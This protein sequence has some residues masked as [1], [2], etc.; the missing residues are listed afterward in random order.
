[1]GSFVTKLNMRHNG[2]NETNAVNNKMKLHAVTSCF[3]FV[4]VD[5]PLAILTYG[6]FYLGGFHASSS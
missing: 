2:E 5:Y 4:Y 1:M 6:M 3:C